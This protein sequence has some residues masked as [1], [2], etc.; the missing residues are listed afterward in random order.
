VGA[1]AGLPLAQLALEADRAAET[2]RDGESQ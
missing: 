1:Q 2:G